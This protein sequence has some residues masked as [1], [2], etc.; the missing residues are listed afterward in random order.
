MNENEI[1]VLNA[2][3]HK[4]RELTDY[5]LNAKHCLTTYPLLIH[6]KLHRSFPL[7]GWLEALDR[8]NVITWPV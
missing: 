4:H 6:D 1:L 2:K 3:E 7:I 5:I 8:V